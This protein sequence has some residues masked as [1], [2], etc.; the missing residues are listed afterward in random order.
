MFEAGT[1]SPSHENAR[2][3]M[4]MIDAYDKARK[5]ATPLVR[6]VAEKYCVKYCKE[7]CWEN[8]TLYHFS[9]RQLSPK[10]EHFC[11]EMKKHSEDYALFPFGAGHFEEELALSRA[12]IEEIAARD[13]YL[14]REEVRRSSILN[15][16]NEREFDYF[17]R[18]IVGLIKGRT[19]RARSMSRKLSEIVELKDGKCFPRP[20]VI[21]NILGK[22]VS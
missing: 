21:A 15:T 8:C 12:Y 7:D 13:E 5:D 3:A 20:E 9:S 2:L 19:V 1:V 16:L 17:K 4:F 6:M 14:E 11:D 18:T 10:A 22:T